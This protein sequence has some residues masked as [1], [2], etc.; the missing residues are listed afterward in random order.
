MVRDVESVGRAPLPILG[1]LVVEYE[2][3]VE[4]PEAPALAVME[5]VKPAASPEPPPRVNAPAIVSAPKET[6]R[7]SQALVSEAAETARKQIGKCLESPGKLNLEIMVD[8]G[9]ARLTRVEW[10]AYDP[11]NGTQRCLARALNAIDFPRNGPPGP[12]RLQIGE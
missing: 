1:L 9:R 3:V 8:A 10:V 2:L 6:Q 5:T 11:K 4:P 12:Y 7:L